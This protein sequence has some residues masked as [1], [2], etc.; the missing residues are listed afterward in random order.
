VRGLRQWRVLARHDVPGTSRCGGVR[1]GGGNGIRRAVRGRARTL[2]TDGGRSAMKNL[3][4]AL[5]FALAAPFAVASW[6]NDTPDELVRALT[7]EVLEIL[8]TDERLKSG[9]SD[10]AVKLM[11]GT[12]L[13]HFDFRRMTLLA[14]GRGWRSASEAQRDRLVDA[15]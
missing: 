1:G 6:P 12:V 13:P 2:R 3:L 9:D 8:Q 4:L 10:R 11:D 15:F 14:V 5:C 7:E